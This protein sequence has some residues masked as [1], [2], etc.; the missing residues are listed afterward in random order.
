MGVFDKFVNAIRINDDEDYDEDDFY[1]EDDDIEDE[2][3]EK[4]KKGFF[5][6]IL[7]GRHSQEDDEFYDDYDEDDEPA[8]KKASAKADPIQKSSKTSAQAS[9]KIAPLRRKNG[10]GME[11]RVIKPTNMEE[12]REI[13]DT[14]IQGC[15]VVLNLEGLDVEVAQRVIDFS[16]GASYAMNGQLQKVSSYIFILTPNG[17]EITGDITDILNSSIPSMRNNL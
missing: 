4:P 10:K 16:S 15:T 7:G 8:P 13:V 2:Q 11:V 1:D 3:E 12:T 9:S 5:K 14:L 17:V 6:R